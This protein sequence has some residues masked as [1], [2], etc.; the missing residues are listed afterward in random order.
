M[1]NEHYARQYGG[2]LILRFDDTN[3]AKAKVRPLLYHP[4]RHSTYRIVQTDF[5]D[6]IKADLAALGFKFD[7]IT[8]SSDSFEKMEQ[9]AENLLKVTYLTS[10]QTH[11]HTVFT[12][13]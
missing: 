4:A 2:Q 7:K 13:W 10:A 8:F 11:I 6:S 1:L 5:M 9:Y 12:C 3:P